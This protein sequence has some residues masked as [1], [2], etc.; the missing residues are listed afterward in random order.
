MLN[1]SPDNI[2]VWATKA[3]K[4]YYLNPSPNGFYTGSDR[5]EDYVGLRENYYYWQWGDALFVVLDPYWY[6]RQN[7]NK[8]NDLWYWTLGEDQYQWLKQ[9]LES[10]G[11]KYKFVFT[12][13][14]TGDVR[15]ILRRWEQET[16]TVFA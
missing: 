16:R 13:H 2:A 15:V 10:S 9:V 1:D 7:P 11:S 3:R 14:L 4:T 8:E 12:H 5:V 6:T